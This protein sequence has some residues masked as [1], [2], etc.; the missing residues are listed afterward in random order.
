[1]TFATVATMITGVLD[2]IVLFLMT[3]SVLAF[4]WGAVRFIYSAGDERTRAQGKQTMVW[5]VLALFSM[6]GIW[7]IVA[8]IKQTFLGT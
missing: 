6:A 4:I 7:G 2:G 3:L 5:G 1:M 8:I